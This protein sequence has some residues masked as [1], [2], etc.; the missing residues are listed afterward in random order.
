[1]RKTIVAPIQLEHGTFNPG[2]QVFAVT[3]CTGKVKVS[4]V[5]Y[6]GYVL[7][8]QYCYKEKK[9]VDIKKA[10]IRRPTDIGEWF[11]KETGE[12]TQWKPNTP[13]LGFRYVPGT[14]VTTLNYNRILPVNATVDE[15]I[16][17][18]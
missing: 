10:Q 8:R 12:K 18:I 3:T 17:E 1:M 4:K 14:R 11:D 6:V 2:D 13:N 5:E 7:A 16:K 15:L 9:Y